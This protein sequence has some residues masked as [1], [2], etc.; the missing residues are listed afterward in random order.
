MTLI[1]KVYFSK[2]YTAEA[3]SKF[4]K[5]IYDDDDGDDDDECS[6]DDDNDPYDPYDPYDM[7]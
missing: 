7:I 1:S 4:C 6:K 5:F 2:V 3:S